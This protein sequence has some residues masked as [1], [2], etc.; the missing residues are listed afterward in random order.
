M[1]NAMANKKYYV[2][3]QYSHD[4]DY[5]ADTIGIFSSLESANQKIIDTI[6]EEY[7]KLDECDIMQIT[8]EWF[9]DKNE[10]YLPKWKDFLKIINKNLK[11]RESIGLSYLTYKIGVHEL[12]K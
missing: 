5:Y 10:E 3:F 8:D 7:D 2:V 1:Y 11:R 9:P 12:E 6:K 4:D